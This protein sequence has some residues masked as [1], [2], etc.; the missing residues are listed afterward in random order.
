MRNLL[1]VL[2]YGT[3]V[4]WNIIDWTSINK[5]FTLII[6]VLTIIYMILKIRSKYLQIKE[7]RKGYFK[8]DYCKKRKA[9]NYKK[10]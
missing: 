3:S 9:L 4:I 5:W 6:S 2:L 8:N 1:G 7:Q 10:H